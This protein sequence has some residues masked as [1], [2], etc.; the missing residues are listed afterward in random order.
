MTAEHDA[1]ADSIVTDEQAA[2][3]F[4][5]ASHRRSRR[6][7]TGAAVAPEILEELDEVC[8]GFR[9]FGDARVVLVREPGDGV[10]Q[11]I[12]GAYGKVSGAPHVLLVV[13]D[14]RTAH[15]HAHAGYTGEAAIL[16]ATALGLDTCWIGGFFRAAYVRRLV[17]LDEGERVIAVSPVGHATGALGVSERMLQ[18]AAGARARKPLEEIAPGI[19]ETWPGWA[20]SAAETVRIGPSAMNRQPWRL[21]MD[22]G[23]LIVSRDTAREAPR[24]TR[25]LDC[26]IAMLHA[27]LGAHHDGMSG[28]WVDAS[29]GLDVARFEPLP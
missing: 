27:E 13:A 21:R 1:P 20:R 18:G 12:V 15:A 9:P 28:R 5:A 14:E 4:E 7:Y 2:I 24:V 22:D 6:R 11:G 26:G 10:F 3:W 16:A 29:G 25:A 19:G 8:E 23:A 17:T